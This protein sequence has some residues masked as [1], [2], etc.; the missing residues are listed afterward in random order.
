M[1]CG[2]VELATNDTG[3]RNFPLRISASMV[4]QITR[5]H[6]AMR[7]M[8]HNRPQPAVAA[9]RPPTRL[10]IPFPGFGSYSYCFWPTD[11]EGVQGSTKALDSGPARLLSYLLA[12]TVTRTAKS[13][14]NIGVCT[15]NASPLY[16]KLYVVAAAIVTLGHYDAPPAR[17]PV[18]EIWADLSTYS[19]STTD[20][21]CSWLPPLAMSGGIRRTLRHSNRVPGKTWPKGLF[22][23]LSA[24]SL[25]MNMNLNLGILNNYPGGE[26]DEPLAEAA[27]REIHVA[28]SSDVKHWRGMRATIASLFK[29]TESP[30]S[31]NVHVFV[32][33]KNGAAPH[34]SRENSIVLANRGTIRV[35]AFTD[36]DIA[37]YVNSHYERA[38]GAI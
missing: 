13:K 35:H 31:I 17:S 12:R 4:A 1:V 9:I 33:T 28:V 6:A 3:L 38:G 16:S 24:C 32:S 20:Q 8:Q 10:K 27:P 11:L 7:Q 26:S 18:P 30:E 14:V 15:A 25:A 37:P 34:R 23:W 5:E 36:G 19:R 22:L 21:P 29:N 2:V